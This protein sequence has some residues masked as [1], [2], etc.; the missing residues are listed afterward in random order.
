MEKSGELCY[1]QVLIF[2]YGRSSN[3]STVVDN[4]SPKRPRRSRSPS[5]ETRARIVEVARIAFCEA[6]FD[7]VGV[8]ELATRAD[9]DPAIVIRLFGSKEALFQEVAKG[10]FT[11]VSAFQAPREIFGEAVADFLFGPSDKDEKDTFDAFRFLLNS[12]GS[13][14]ASSIVS[15]SLHKSFIE[16]LSELLGPDNAEARAVLVAACV[17]GFTTM[18]F[19]LRAPTLQAE[20]LEAVRKPFAAAIQACIDR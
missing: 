6:G 3:L 17:L 14:V 9:T 18:R 12:A 16:P 15:E 13:P 11:F 1:Q 7:H 10:A 4:E 19:A 8:R 20:R 2:K 5:E